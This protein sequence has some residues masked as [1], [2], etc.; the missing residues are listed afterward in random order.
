MDGL[1]PAQIE[2]NERIQKLPVIIDLAKGQA[3]IIDMIKEDKEQNKTQ[4]DEGS[5]KFKELWD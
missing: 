2:E 3:Q 4:F 5:V 1:T